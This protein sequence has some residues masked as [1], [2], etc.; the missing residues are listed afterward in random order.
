MGKHAA[1]TTPACVCLV[2]SALWAQIPP[3]NCAC[4]D[5]PSTPLTRPAVNAVSISPTIQHVQLPQSQRSRKKR[6]THKNLFE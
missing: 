2:Q 3:N 6:K 5:L 4:A 1:Q